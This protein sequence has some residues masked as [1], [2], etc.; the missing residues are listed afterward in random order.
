MRR[1]GSPA[2]A[3]LLFCRSPKRRGDLGSAPLPGQIQRAAD[4]TAEIIEGPHRQVEKRNRV[5]EIVLYAAR[6]RNRFGDAGVCRCHRHELRA[7][8]IM[9]L[10]DALTVASEE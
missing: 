7:I 3:T 2:V 8:V 1:E 6:R 4:E 5:E 9:M 10:R